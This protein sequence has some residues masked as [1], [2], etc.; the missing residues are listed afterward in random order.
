MTEEQARRAE[1]IVKRWLWAARLSVSTDRA[2]EQA[3]VGELAVALIEQLV[4]DRRR[5]REFGSGARAA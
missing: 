1:Q 2:L 3:A 5:A 4:G